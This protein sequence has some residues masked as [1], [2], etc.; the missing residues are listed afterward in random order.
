MGEA[1]GP[2]GPGPGGR[3]L[4]F[5][6]PLLFDRVPGS[7]LSGV[8]PRVSE[9]GNVLFFQA[10]PGYRADFCTCPAAAQVVGW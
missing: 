1:A 8:F 5:L 3:G 6:S 10:A 2:A 7:I 9:L 4:Q